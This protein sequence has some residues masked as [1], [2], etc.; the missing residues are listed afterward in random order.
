[1]KKMLTKTYEILFKPYS[2]KVLGYVARFDYSKH[3]GEYI[4][5][6][7]NLPETSKVVVQSKLQE[8]SVT[9]PNHKFILLQD[10]FQIYKT[11]NLNLSEMSE[12]L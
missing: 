12:Q 7:S 5:I 4:V 10:D 8:Y 9:F 2:E 3:T 1:M 11:E 6:N